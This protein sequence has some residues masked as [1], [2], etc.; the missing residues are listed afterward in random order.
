M[1]GRP[2]SYRSYRDFLI[3][4]CENISKCQRISTG[5]RETR[6]HIDELDADDEKQSEERRR[7]GA[8]DGNGLVVRLVRETVK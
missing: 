3:K 2:W 5:K 6:N 1:G 7:V 8:I 4:N